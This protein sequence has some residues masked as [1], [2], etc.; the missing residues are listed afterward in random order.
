MKNLSKCV[1]V[2]FTSPVMEAAELDLFN[3]SLEELL[4]VKV[5]VSTGSQRDR[6]NVPSSISVYT[7]QDIER[8][9]LRTLEQLLNLST[10]MQVSRSDAEG[11]SYGPA[12]RGK[13]ADFV[14]REILV[15]L[16]GLRLN[17]VVTGGVFGQDKLIT[18]TNVKR[19]EIIRGPGSS[20]YGANAY[21]GVV[22]I[23]SDTSLNQVTLASGNFDSL[24]GS[25]SKSGQ[26]SSFHYSFFY[27][28]YQDEGD[29]YNP[30]YNFQGQ[31]EATSDPVSRDNLQ[32]HLT[33]EQL[34][35]FYRYSNTI[36][37]DFIIGGG[38]ASSG[39]RSD[40]HSHS[41]RAVY[42]ANYNGFK[43]TPYADT[44]ESTH[45]VTLGLFPENPNP[46][47]PV[48]SLYWTNGSSIEMLGGNIRD[49]GSRNV[50]VDIQKT[51]SNHTISFGV[52]WM[53]EFTGL[54][55]FQTNIDIPHL[56]ATGELI[57]SPNNMLM[58]GFYIGGIRFDLLEA[59][60]RISK[61][62]YIQDEWQINDN[63]NVTLGGRYDDYDDFGGNFS[64]RSSAIYRVDD[65]NTLKVLYGEAYRAPS[66]TETRAGIASG[67]IS[68]P[69]LKPETVS[70]SEIAWQRAGERL[71]S[72]V[73][74][75]NNHYTDGIQPVLVDDVVPG[76]TAY[77]P[78]NISNDDISGLEVE[79]EYLIDANFSAKLSGS[80][81]FNLVE[82]E[83]VAKELMQ[84]SINYRNSAWNVNASAYYHGEVPSRAESSNS[85][86]IV[87]SGFWLFNLSSQYEINPNLIVSF[88]MYNAGDI[89]Y[90]TYSP[91]AGIENGLPGRGRQVMAGIKYKF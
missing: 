27:E 23:I 73:T 65:A 81:F 1:L 61:G 41:L 3:L 82:T 78:Q 10:S 76:F 68:N 64:L 46:V 44:T 50:G 45:D 63:L 19:V 17:D 70:T 14:G 26:I 58:Q 66:F 28:R 48:S 34:S 18:L 55:P 90:S 75:F 77:Q 33:Y 59:S 31:Y 53:K 5:E 47:P 43:I 7:K 60:E 24:H 16:D 13:K 29:S 15:L 42:H 72:T 69:S 32:L 86:E 40:Q 91:Q 38:Q 74:L 54:N 9:G 67:G 21:A 49:V 51:W 80:Q 35:L 4:Q 25:L 30:F 12:V 83:A 8:L 11:I 36:T 22:N 20:L 62:A 56:E 57:P 52:N 2:L 6:S 71:L 87:L 85:N 84:V 79:I 88:D 37:S 89:E 39:S